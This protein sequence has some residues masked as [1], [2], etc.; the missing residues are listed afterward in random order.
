MRSLLS[1]VR[2]PFGVGVLVDND[3][4]SVRDAGQGESVVFLLLLPRRGSRLKASR[5]STG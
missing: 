1:R 3:L 5:P 2:G 4:V